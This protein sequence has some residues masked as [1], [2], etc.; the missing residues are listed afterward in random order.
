MTRPAPPPADPA[1]RRTAAILVR[2]SPAELKLLHAAA[3]AAGLKLGAWLRH[4][5][6]EASAA[7]RVR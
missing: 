5:G 2:L 6:I 1:A 7:A 4:L 3:A